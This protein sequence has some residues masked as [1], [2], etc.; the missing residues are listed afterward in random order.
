MKPSKLF[1]LQ[2][3]RGLMYFSY[4]LKKNGNLFFSGALIRHFMLDLV[5]VFNIA[6]AT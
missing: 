1:I 4:A 5:C 6:S 2:F 3:Q